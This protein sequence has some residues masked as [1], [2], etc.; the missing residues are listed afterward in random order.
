MKKKMIPK[1]DRQTKSITI[2][3][4]EDFLEELK[5]VAPTKG[6]S[7]YQPLMKFYISQGLRKDLQQI[8]EEEERAKELEALLNKFQLKEE[9]KNEIWHFLRDIPKARTA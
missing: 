3:M 8:W 4:P 2:R 7:A 1:N 9:E 6:M 5:R